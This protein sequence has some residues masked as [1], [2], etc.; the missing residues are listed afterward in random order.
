MSALVVLGGEAIG[1]DPDLADLAL[2]REAAAAEAV[3]A[4]DG[5]R[6]RAPLQLVLHLLR[7]VGQGSDLLRGQDLR[8]R[9]LARERLASVLADRDLLLAAGESEPHGEQAARIGSIT[10][11]G[12]G[13]KPRASTSNVQAAASAA[14]K[15]ASPFDPSRPCA[16]APART[17][18]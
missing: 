9:S 16:I 17:A 8:E 1:L 14:G 5:A 2:G 10:G 3:D 6:A 18:A 11:S 13:S 4:Q 15:T 12:R 7:V